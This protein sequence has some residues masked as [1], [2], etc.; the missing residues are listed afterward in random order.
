MEISFPGKPGACG[1]DVVVVGGVAGGGIPKAVAFAR[2]LL[3]LLLPA[4]SASLQ[5]E[6]GQSLAAGH[7]HTC[8]VT[9]AGRL[10][11]WGSNGNGQIGDGGYQDQLTAVD[12]IGLGS[13]VVSA[14][15][16]ADYSCALTTSG[17]AQCWGSNFL[18]QL[19][20]GSHIS[21]PT[22]GDVAGLAS[23]V[24]AIYAGFQHACA[25]T[26]AGG[27]K[28]WGSNWQGQLGDGS[29]TDR[30][31]AVD[32]EGLDAGVTAISAGSLLTCALTIGG[33]VKC[34]GHNGGGALGDGTTVR[35]LTPVDVVGLQSGVIAIAVETNGSCAVLAGGAVKCW[36]GGQLTPV[37]VPTLQSGVRA[38]AVGDSHRCALRDSGAVEC[39][40]ANDFG[41]LGDGTPFGHAEPAPVTGL[42]AHIVE[43]AAGASH[44][45]AKADNG[46]IQCWGHDLYGQLGDGASTRHAQP[47]DVV[48]VDTQFTQLAS[49]FQ[50]NCALTTTGSVRCWGSNDSGALG[51][52]TWDQR[53]LAVEVLGLD[54]PATNVAAGVQF[55]CAVMED[56]R[57]RC[58]GAPDVAG[59]PTATDVP[60]LQA[61]I[62]RVSAGWQSQHA[63]AI[64]QAGALKCW[65][66]N[67]DGQ[68]GDGT[69]ADQ[70]S[71]VDVTGLG[72]EV[73][74]V[75][76]GLGHTCALTAAGAVKCWGRN[77]NGELG[78]GTIVPHA[79]P[80][81]VAGLDSG[82]SAVSAGRNHTCA[83]M[84]D[85]GIKCWGD[86]AFGKLGD[87]SQ[88]QQLQPV[89]VM[90]FG[91]FFEQAKAVSAGDMHT[92]A[93]TTAGAARCWGFNFYGQLGNGSFEH[94][95]GTDGDVVGLSSGVSGISASF[96]HT[97]AVMD[98]GVAKCWG[99]N[100]N[101]QLGNGEAGPL[102]PR[103]VV[104]SPFDDELFGDGF[105][106]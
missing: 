72:A 80:G 34:W 57:A 38:I 3:L 18:G 67:T 91:E 17:G 98:S 78:D 92:C 35:R 88:Q 59:N 10:K 32:V 94:S 44:T 39:W 105:D 99:H 106:E 14:S 43:I 24:S 22:A 46:A 95:Q 53:P 93:V 2:L 102:T 20:D 71:A 25:L 103:D 30:L 36:G 97:C 54:M 70:V 62:V 77:E 60:G 47:V 41:Q 82:V 83:L 50:H 49:G 9:A 100:Q 61:D 96:E 19:G 15:A 28:C 12:V 101:G 51:D 64:T 5:A 65:G 56:G 66:R 52:G 73:V 86:N 89:D 4:T 40:G 81:D 79:L 58:W 23:G 69:Y 21:R 16:G 11:C 26:D 33:A 6:S 42:V 90:G 74:S 87:G 13:G 63:C 85:G 75:T 45:C 8:T 7:G 76:T 29:T 48:V 27:V 1:R 37:D 84:V 55:G 104:G 68:L 31:T